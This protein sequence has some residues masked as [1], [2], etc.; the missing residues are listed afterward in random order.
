LRGDAGACILAG[1]KK[2]EAG[3]ML[4]GTM[5]AVSL[6]AATL[7]GPCWADRQPTPP[8]QPT[9]D[10]TATPAPQTPPPR[11]QRPPRQ[12]MHCESTYTTGSNMPTRTCVPWDE[13]EA[14]QAARQ[15]QQRNTSDRIAA[16]VGEG[17]SNC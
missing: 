1:N 12:R 15:Q 4:R 2:R 11:P 3:V 10:I 8:P 7:S 6:A 16:C 9:S 5:L 14:Q 13:W 17:F